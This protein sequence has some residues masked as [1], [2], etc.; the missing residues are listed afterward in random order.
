M[1]KVTKDEVRNS[2][3]EF[4]MKRLRNK[5]IAKPKRYVSDDCSGSYSV[6]DKGLAK[7]IIN[8][9]ASYDDEK[10]SHALESDQGS[11]AAKV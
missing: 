5:K 10:A 6:E 4:A 9:F 3:K 7:S 1:I 2:Y 11:D 8:L